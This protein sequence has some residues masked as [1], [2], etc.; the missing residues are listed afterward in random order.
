MNTY[1]IVWEDES[2]AREVEL[3]VNY[4]AE[5]GT[6]R[7]NDIRPHSVTFYNAETKQAERVV[8]VHTESGRKLLTR[9]Y[10]AARASEMTLED[11]IHAQLAQRDEAVMTEIAC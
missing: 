1:R 8:G 4:A 9:A 7:V 2:K 5:A 3:L 11:E 6:V 10:L